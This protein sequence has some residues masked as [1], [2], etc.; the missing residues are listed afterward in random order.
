MSTF[1]E[2]INQGY[3][4]GAAATPPLPS[5]SSFPIGNQTSSSEAANRNTSSNPSSP[6]PLPARPLTYS[7]YQRYQPYTGLGVGFPNYGSFGSYGYN[8]YNQGGYNSHHISPER[9]MQFAEEHSLPGFQ[10]LESVVRTFSSVSYMLDSTFYAVNSSFHAILGVA[11]HLSKV[12][13]QLSQVFSAISTIKIIKYLYTKFMQLFGLKRANEEWS[14]H[15][16][17]SLSSSSQSNQEGG[18]SNIH[19]HQAKGK[20]SRF[21]YSCLVLSAPLLIWKLIQPMLESVGQTS[22]AAED[23]DW[24][25]GIGEHYLANVLFQFTPGSSGELGIEAGK[26]IRVAPQSKQPRVRGWLLAACDGKTG[27]VPANYIKILGKT[28]GK[29]LQ[30]P[31]VIQQ[32]LD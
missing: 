15:L 24:V 30:Q 11:E 21:L 27:L 26:K 10:Y 6:P 28:E 18:I 7:P 8:G 1:A 13:L 25:Q 5:R 4:L 9:L 3:G 12:K 16:W 22:P 17:S 14:D 20:L 23:Q 29:Q 2:N 19:S 31:D 32:V